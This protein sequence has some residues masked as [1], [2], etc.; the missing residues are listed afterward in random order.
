[1]F[2]CIEVRPSPWL[3]ALRGATLALSPEGQASL[4]RCFGVGQFRSFYFRARLSLAAI[5][6]KKPLEGFLYASE[7]LEAGVLLD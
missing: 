7:G 5:F 4:E 1:M 6:Q 3:A 2:I